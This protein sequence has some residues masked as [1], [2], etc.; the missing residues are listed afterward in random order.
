[1]KNLKRT[2]TLFVAVIMIAALCATPAFAAT[3]RQEVLHAAAN[4]L[5]DELG[6]PNDHA[7]VRTMSEC[8][9]VEAGKDASQSYYYSGR[10]E[11]KY[12]FGQGNSN[13]AYTGGY[14]TT[15]RRQEAAARAVGMLAT[16]Y[17]AG[18]PTV[19]AA[20]DILAAECGVSC[21]NSYFYSGIDGKTYYFN[22]SAETGNNSSNTATGSNAGVPGG[23]NNAGAGNNAGNGNNAGTGNAGN[24]G[25]G[26]GTG[27]G[28]PD[29]SYEYRLYSAQD[30]YTGS[31]FT[32][33][34]KWVDV[35][36][37]TIVAKF[38]S[39]YGSNE[40]SITK[41]A[42]LGWTCINY[43]T[44]REATDAVVSAAYGKYNANAS[45]TD[46]YGRDLTTLAKD[47]LFRLNAEKV[48]IANVGR[49]LPADY[50]RLWVMSDGT[51]YFRNKEGEN[52]PNWDFSL[53]S[54][55]NS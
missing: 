55:Y 37:A 39:S 16:I 42:A 10:T 28:T 8:W 18:H 46:A 52:A 26:T 6:W 33:T 48:G 47:L 51:V 43:L 50:G 32:G 23:S 1:M 20:N 17:G 35:N 21:I 2:L 22:G 38:I 29:T 24:T 30:Y 27:T 36:K 7:A 3:P 4:V 31:I 25:A 54:P 53:K 34:D 5:R 12:Y 19:A 41:Q 13:A 11:Q 49:V 14:S 15:N 44:G 9:N 45:T 40:P